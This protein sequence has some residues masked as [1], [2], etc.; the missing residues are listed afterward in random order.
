MATLVRLLVVDEY[1]PNPRFLFD[2][3]KE[4]LVIGEAS[5]GLEAVQKAHATTGRDSARHRI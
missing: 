5:D 3:G 2:T 1:E 4:L